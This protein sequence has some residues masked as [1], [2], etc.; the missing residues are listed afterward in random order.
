M[1]FH[2][3]MWLYVKKLKKNKIY[4]YFINYQFT[5]YKM[6]KAPED[7]TAE[8]MIVERFAVVNGCGERIAR[9]AYRVALTNPV[10]TA[11]PIQL[12]AKEIK[13]RV[14]LLI[15]YYRKYISHKGISPDLTQTQLDDIMVH[16]N[17]VINNS[18]VENTLDQTFQTLLELPTPQT[19]GK[20]GKRKGGKWSMKYKRS[21]NCRAPRGFSQRQHCKYGRRKTAKK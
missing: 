16:I 9:S 13:D 20:R 2:V 21:I 12:R 5:N 17:K 8:E 3:F 18:P 14:A 4:A 1:T 11:L 19:G 6:S 10:N 7:M 15:S